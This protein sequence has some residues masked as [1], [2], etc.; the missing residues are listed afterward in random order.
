[1]LEKFVSTRSPGFAV[2][3][4]ESGCG[5]TITRAVLHELLLSGNNVVVEFENCL[6]GFDGLL[7]ECVSQ[8]RN[9][10]VSSAEFP[11]RYSRLAEFKRCLREYVI[12]Q[13]KHLVIVLDEAQQLDIATL[14][15]VRALGNIVAE[16]QHFSSAILLGLP[17]LNETLGTMPA[18][19]ARIE[20]RIHLEPL[21]PAEML[22]YLVHRMGF[23][24]LQVSPPFTVDSLSLLGRLTNGVPR[25]VNRIC[26]QALNIA[27][28]REL[29]WLDANLI[30]QVA[31][32][33]AIGID[34]APQLV[35]S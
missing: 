27:A 15:G 28:E 13:N 31:C 14:E 24:G 7:L 22:R 29:V 9:T 32:D 12:A 4:G 19:E 16:R 33:S 5:K 30:H 6:L 1:M 8:L 20:T 17:D 34:D 21:G 35:A 10:R 3:T 25:Q 23:A 18:L 2:L 11:D 26:R